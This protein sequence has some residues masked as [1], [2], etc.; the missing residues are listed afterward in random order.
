V[1][2]GWHQATPAA[3]APSSHYYFKIKPQDHDEDEY[4][5]YGDGDWVVTVGVWCA[6]VI[7]G[8][9][10]VG[11]AENVA[12]AHGKCFTVDTAENVARR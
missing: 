1:A 3:G 4:I 6:L 5:Q 2:P 11:T 10:S 7:V 8:C 9:C 12:V